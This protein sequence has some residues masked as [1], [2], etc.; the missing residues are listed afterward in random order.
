MNQSNTINKSKS[1]ILTYFW[2]GSKSSVPMKCWLLVWKS[3]S[4]VPT[5]ISN[6]NKS[7]GRSESGS[8]SKKSSLNNK[9]N[10]GDQINKCNHGTKTT[11]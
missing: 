7:K 5:N 4:E 3:I 1:K 11:N 2:R 6:D 9:S 8:N 10:Q